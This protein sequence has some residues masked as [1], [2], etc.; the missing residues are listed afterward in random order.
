[1][2]IDAKIL[3]KIL[4]VRIQQPTAWAL[5]NQLL[6]SP[7]SYGQRGRVPNSLMS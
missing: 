7:F 3:N 2:N 1:M 5:L 6:L 4:A